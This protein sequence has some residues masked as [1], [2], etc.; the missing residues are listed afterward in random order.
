[1]SLGF[2]TNPEGS[3]QLW[4]CLKSFTSAK[5][6]KQTWTDMKYVSQSVLSRFSR[7]RFIICFSI[8]SAA[9]TQPAGSFSDILKYRMMTSY[10]KAQS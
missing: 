5:Q 3:A 10:L 2:P 9:V 6:Q 4:E 1:M 8:F 7:D